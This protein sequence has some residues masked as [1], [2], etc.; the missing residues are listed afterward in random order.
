MEQ[1]A[2]AGKGSSVFIKDADDITVF[3]E[4]LLE[5]VRSAVSP[6]LQDFSIRFD[7][8]V[9]ERAIPEPKSVSF[10]L[11]D[12]AFSLNLIFKKDYI[13]NNN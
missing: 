9:F 13:S 12:E 7:S 8:S 4:K 3:K 1:A 11:K 10:L 5:Q 2:K 6:Y